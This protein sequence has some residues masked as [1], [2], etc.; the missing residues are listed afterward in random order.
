MGQQYHPRHCQVGARELRTPRESHG[1]HRQWEVC[2]DEGNLIIY[3]IDQLISY[4][5]SLEVRGEK[6]QS[7]KFSACS[8]G[9]FEP[10]RC[11][12]LEQEEIPPESAWGGGHVL[13]DAWAGAYEG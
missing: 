10:Q 11:C 2:P 7:G 3:N 8:P 5:S 12:H 4:C 1:C 6:L 9:I 13:W